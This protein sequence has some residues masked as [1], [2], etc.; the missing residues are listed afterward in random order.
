M[1]IVAACILSLLTIAALT[2]FMARAEPVVSTSATSGPS[3]FVPQSRRSHTPQ[4]SHTPRPVA[5]AS[6]AGSASQA[7]RGTVTSG[8]HAAAPVAKAKS[9]CSQAVWVPVQ[10]SPE[11]QKVIERCQALSPA[12]PHWIHGIDCT[13][14][15]C[16]PSGPGGPSGEAHWNQAGPIDWQY[17]AQGEYIGPARLR[18]VPSY[19]LRVDDQLELVYRVTRDEIAEPYELNVGDQVRVESFTDPALNRDLIIQPDGTITVRL[20]GQ[21]RAAGRTVE[22]LRKDLESRYR[23]YYHEP[24]ITVTP[25]RVNTKLEDL[26]ATVD[27]RFGQGGQSRLARITPEGTISLPVL[28]TVVAHGL[29]LDELEVELN[30]R[31]AMEIKGIEVT[32]VLVA[33]A[34]RFVFVLGEVAVPGRYTLDSPTTVMGG[35]ALAGGWNVGGNLRQVVVF[36]RG[37]DWRLM[38]TM[39]D[40]RGA[41]LGKRPC[42]ADEIWLRDSDIVVVPKTPIL[43]ADEFIDLVFTRGLYGV[44]PV[45][46]SINFSKLSTL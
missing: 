45:S 12:A 24:A 3:G 42:P 10:L 15:S 1:R 2:V 32:P 28:G 11:A 8:S 21:I 4:G 46:T 38:A 13:A 16:C 23:R 43:L 36:R 25:L 17:F 19:R 33:R 34:P 18:H 7:L 40:L 29:T 6:Q 44:L 22:Q 35:I 39:L 27:S 9:G 31:Y 14:G 5:Q 41:L 20:L 37:D 30:E 26:R